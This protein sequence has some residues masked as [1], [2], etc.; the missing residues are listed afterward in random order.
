M[1]SSI[2]STI[3]MP[4]LGQILSSALEKLDNPIAQQAAKGLKN[5]DHDLTAGEIAE[6]NRHAEA[7]TALQIQ[8][9]GSALAEINKTIQKEIASHDMFVRR[10]RPTFGYFMAFT[11]GAQMLSL[12]YIM[13]TSPELAGPILT[14]M[15]HLTGIWG[16]G[17]SVLG[18]YVYKRS[19]E[20]RLT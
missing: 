12:A 2:L 4:M 18:I 13:V 19:E 7:M 17:L 6:A 11:W 1:L 9:Q 10:M 5:L 14:G 15:S 3:G 8:E 20:K 16:V